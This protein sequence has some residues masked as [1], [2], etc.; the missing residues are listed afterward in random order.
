MDISVGATILPTVAWSLRRKREGGRQSTRSRRG[1]HEGP[2]GSPEGLVAHASC[3]TCH[4][5]A[6]AHLDMYPV[7][8]TELSTCADRT[9]AV[10]CITRWQ[11]LS[12]HGVGG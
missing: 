12:G 4:V 10:A 5:T 2:H 1:N 9:V 11:G 7:P 8:S 3:M 6:L